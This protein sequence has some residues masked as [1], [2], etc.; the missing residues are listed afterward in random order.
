MSVD[1]NLWMGDIKPWMDES[2]ILHC[3]YSYNIYP[4]NI[5]LIRDRITS[6]TKNYCFVEFTNVDEANKCLKLLNGEFIPNTNFKFRLNWSN[7]FSFFNRNVY[8]GNLSSDVDDISLYRLFKEKYKSVHHASVMIENGKSKGYGFILFCNEEEYKKC[9]REMNGIQFHGNIIKVNGQKKKED[10]KLL[11]SFYI[12]DLDERIKNKNKD[13]LKL[14]NK[15]DNNNNNN[16]I[17]YFFCYKKK[18]DT[19]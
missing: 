17:N 4:R 7:Y 1:N 6:E 14:L 11:N 2:F 10:K 18:W 3:F 15:N 19:R 5:K 16:N 8:V 12:D 9:L 13:N